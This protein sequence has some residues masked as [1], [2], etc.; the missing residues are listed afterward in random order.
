MSRVLRLSLGS[1][2]SLFD[3]AGGEMEAEIVSLQDDQV[4]VKIVEIISSGIQNPTG[5]TSTPLSIELA[6][7][8]LKSGKLETVFRMASELGVRGFHLFTSEYTV[9]RPAPARLEKKYE[10]WRRIILDSVRISGLRYLPCLS[11]VQPFEILLPR[12]T[13]RSTVLL[14]HPGEDLANGQESQLML[15]EVFS[16]GPGRAPGKFQV[17]LVTGPEGGFTSQEVKTA[18]D[19]GVQ[20]CSLGDRILRA[21][22]APVAATCVILTRFGEI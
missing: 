5:E 14:A 3:G 20:I 13:E 4:K 6:L 15:P 7:P 21:E 1:R 11:Q 12:L 10:R 9:P 8:L 22:T 16:P 2:I 18:R 19:C 17:C